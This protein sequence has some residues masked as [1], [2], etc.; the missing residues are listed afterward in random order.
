MIVAGV[1]AVEKWDHF[2]RAYRS[3]AGQPR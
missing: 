2:A 3:S 1:N